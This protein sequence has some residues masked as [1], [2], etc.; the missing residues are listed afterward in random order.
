MII[1][2]TNYPVGIHDLSFTKS[3]NELHLEEP[4][5]DNLILDCRLDKSQ[6]QIV[7]KCNLT[8]SV[9]LICDRCGEE[10]NSDVNSKF[11]LIYLF[12]SSA[13]NIDETNVKFLALTEDRIDITDD[14]ID[15]ANL[16]IPMKRLCSEDCK[17]L[18]L[19]CGTNLNL[20]SCNCET[21][22]NN[23]MWDKLLK[24]KDKLN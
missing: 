8:I 23:P 9:K 22:N 21:E 24:L 11:S 5:I 19:S 13:P 1:K 12:D 3:V 2:I 17:G 20:K 4:F 10:F 14:V 18:C 15:Y 16:S 7:L 6:H